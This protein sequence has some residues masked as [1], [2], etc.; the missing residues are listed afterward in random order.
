MLQKTFQDVLLLADVFEAFK[1]TYLQHY[2]LDPSHYY[3]SPGLALDAALK[4]TDIEIDLISDSPDKC[5]IDMHLF[6]ESGI[7]GGGSVIS[8]RHARANNPLVEGYDNIQPTKHLIYWDANNLYGWAMSQYLPY[9]G[10]RWLTGEEI[11]Q[12]DITSVAEDAEAGYILEVDF[13]Y[14]SELHNL[15]GDYP[16]APGKSCSL[17]RT[18]NSLFKNRYTEFAI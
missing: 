7:R 12:L 6:M 14:P 13:E 4:M 8:H 3:T 16:L 11:E 5:N 15:H 10:L 17:P 2:S 1:T 18:L 9:C